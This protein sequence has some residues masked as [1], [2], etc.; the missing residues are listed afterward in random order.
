MYKASPPLKDLGL[1]N[2]SRAAFFMCDMQEKFRPAMIH[3]DEIVSV[4]KK[5]VEVSKVMSIPLVV[6]E[7]YPRGLG[8]TVP[9]IDISK[10]LI[11]VSKTRFS[12]LV[13][14]VERLLHSLCDGILESVVLFG[15]ETHI[16]VEQ[17]AIELLSRNLKVHIIADACTSRNNADRLLALDRL[18][19]IGCF[20]TTS[21]TVIFKILQDKDNPKFAEIRHLVK[22]PSPYTG[23]FPGSYAKM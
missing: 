12:M 3:F 22:E 1:L 6:T 11:V 8:K 16:C 9:D 23:L 21:E 4:A 5:M 2:P 18:R 17:T 13:P 7:Q 10:A 20:V 14:D 15:I 19:Q